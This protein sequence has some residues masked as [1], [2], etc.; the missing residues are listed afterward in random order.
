MNAIYNKLKTWEL[1]SNP[2]AVSMLLHFIS[3]ATSVSICVASKTTHRGQI[4]TT[5]GFLAKELGMSKRQVRTTLNQLVANGDIARKSAQRE[6][7]ITVCDYDS[8][9]AKE[10][11]KDTT[12]H[13]IKCEEKLINNVREILHRPEFTE[14]KGMLNVRYP[15]NCGGFRTPQVT[16]ENEVGVEVRIAEGVEVVRKEKI[17]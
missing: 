13:T 15:I 9:Q 5:L 12:Y 11:P 6:T 10:N 14:K 1:K 17:L 4:R 3:H 8:Y 16:F 2:R 7:L